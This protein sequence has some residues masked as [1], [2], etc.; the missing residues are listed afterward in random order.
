[1]GKLAADRGTDLRH[2][3]H[4]REAVKARKQRI[5]QGRGNRKRR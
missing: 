1:M 4:W 3:L 2:F 5:M